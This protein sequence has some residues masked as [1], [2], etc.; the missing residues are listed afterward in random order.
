[1]TWTDEEGIHFIG[2]GDA[3]DSND[4]KK[5]TDEYQQLIRKSPLWKQM[6]Q[7]Y[8]KKQAEVMLKDFQ[9]KPG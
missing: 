9:V 2:S 6:V 4:I 8:G 1:M 5:I 7:Q 3:P